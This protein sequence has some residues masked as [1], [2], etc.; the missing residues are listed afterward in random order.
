MAIGNG[1]ASVIYG[2]VNH[3][4]PGN[5]GPD[6]TDY[7]SGQQKI[8]ETLAFTVLFGGQ[9]VVNWKKC[10]GKLPAKFRY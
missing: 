10:V 3:S 1:L 2:G 9:V 7:I 6:C 8:V 4:I 5:G